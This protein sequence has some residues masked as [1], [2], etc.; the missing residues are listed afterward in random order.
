MKKIIF[1]FAFCFA[2]INLFSS[3]LFSEEVRFDTRGKS[4]WISFPPN[5]HNFKFSGDPERRNGDSISIY[6][7]AEAPTSGTI[8]YFDRDGNEYVDEFRIDDISQIYKFALN[9]QNFD[10]ISINNS[11]FEDVSNSDHLK[12]TKLSF[13]VETDEDVR[14]YANN[15][16]VTTTDAMLIYPESTLST[17]YYIT[18]YYSDPG[19]GQGT[20][21]QFVVLAVEDNTNIVINPSD[22]VQGVGQRRIETTL[23][24]GESY[25]VQTPLTF[26]FLDLTGTEI[27]SDKPIA[28]FAGHQRARVRVDISGN[29]S[30]DYLVEQMP[31]L[32]VWGR[33]AFLIPYPEFGVASGLENNSDLFRIVAAYDNTELIE[34][35]EVFAILDEGEF[36][37]GQLVEPLFVES[38]KPILV[39]QIK[40]TSSTGGSNLLDGDPFLTVVPTAELYLNNYRFVNIQAWQFGNFGFDKEKVY[41]QQYVT[42]VARESIFGLIELDGQPLDALSTINR[43][44]GSE[45]VYSHLRVDDGVHFIEGPEEFGIYVYGIG[46]ANSYGYTGG[47]S[48]KPID[49][50]PP[51]IESAELCFEIAG[52]VTDT[53]VLD[54]GISEVIEIES[55]NENVLVDIEEFERYAEIVQYGGTLINRYLDGVFAIEVIDSMGLSDKKRYE[56]PGFTVGVDVEINKADENTFLEFDED[57]LL[58]EQYCQ[59]ITIEN[60]GN[61]EQVIDDIAFRNFDINDP[62]IFVND[63]DLPIILSPGQTQDIEICVLEERIPALVDELILINSC[64]ERKIAEFRVRF[65]KDETTPKI[66]KQDEDPCDDIIILDITES[67]ALDFGFGEIRILEEDNCEISIISENRYLIRLSIQILNANQ[68]AS[69]SFLAVDAEGNETEYS[70]TIQGFTL[71]FSDAGSDLNPEEYDFGTLQYTDFECGFRELYNYGDEDIILEDA[72]MF[73]NLYFS[74]PMSQFPL[75]IPAQK[76]ARVHFCYKPEYDAL[77]IQNDTLM[78]K[79]ICN[80]V[81]IPIVG[82]GIAF[83]SGISVRCD[84]PVKVTIGEG[85]EGSEILLVSPNPVL[86]DATVRFSV[87]NEGIIKLSLLNSI[88]DEIDVLLESNYPIGVYE[89]RV[90]L[91]DIVSGAYF[92]MIEDGL[93]IDTYPITVE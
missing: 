43:I 92:I 49:H 23:D 90:D 66:S 50:T 6:V 69:Y 42:V 60:Y 41:N 93:S 21:S 20:P 7:A 8:T 3:E 73:D 71:S 56:I 17:Q 87:A 10:I 15:Q 14:V 55:E 32:D 74:I 86:S 44:P 30:R 59:T 62:N 89:I 47:M 36:Y 12:P 19:L 35:G 46:G 82:R 91:S 28:V 22:E 76:A 18:S 88:G 81:L 31:P 37:E 70:E 40:K 48:V 45:Y 24:R 63:I 58:R 77:G 53:T 29:M 9:H 4:F 38:N 16:A 68:A 54:D 33:S 25:L 67:E 79:T 72:E 57:F 61:Y 80:D 84:L 13:H 75:V 1:Y 78:I 5:F 83:E 85:K 65:A 39:S 11:G 26:S 64:A 34:G 51:K 52:V 27:N 2:L